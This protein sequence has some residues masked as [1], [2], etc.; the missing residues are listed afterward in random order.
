[1]LLHRH[2]QKYQAIW[3]MQKRV[4][5]HQCPHRYGIVVYCKHHKGNENFAGKTN[6]IATRNLL[7]G[8]DMTSMV[9]G[10]QKKTRKSAHRSGA[11]FSK[12]METAGRDQVRE[13]NKDFTFRTEAERITSKSH[14]FRRWGGADA[15]RLMVTASMP[16]DCSLSG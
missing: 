3:T 12:R 7:G 16:F 6:Q 2:R 10:E 5:F 15:G 4:S 8:S 11:Y 1:M 14:F 9:V 13:G